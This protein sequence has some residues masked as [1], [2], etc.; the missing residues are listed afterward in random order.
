MAIK[1]KIRLH[2][3]LRSKQLK[4]NLIEVCKLGKTIG[5]KGAIKLHNYSD[6]PEQFKKGAKFYDKN[7]KEFVI[8]SFDKTNFTVI[9]DGFFDIDLAKTLTNT[10]LYRTL[11]D[12]K[13]YCKLKKDEFFY[14]DIIGCE[15]VED[16]QILG[17]VSDILEIGAGFLFAIK[18]SQNF[19]TY[20]KE[21]FIPYLDNF[22]QKVDL[23]KK[24]IFVKNSLEILKNS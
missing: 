11:E 6:F 9:F 10:T 23:D 1:Q 8:F 3:E 12:T 14:F 5:L 19:S 20:P 18:T 4:N 2:I 22:V 7:G 15:I 17:I 21:F 24:Q 16:N 13:K